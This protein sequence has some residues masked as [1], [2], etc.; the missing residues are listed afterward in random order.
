MSRDVSHMSNSFGRWYLPRR[1][2]E[3]CLVL[4]LA[5]NLGDS[6][7]SVGSSWPRA[8]SQRPLSALR[9]AEPP[10]SAGSSQWLAGRGGALVPF[11][12]LAYPTPFACT[13]VARQTRP[14][15]RLQQLFAPASCLHAILD[16]RRHYQGWSRHPYRPTCWE[17][18]TVIQIESSLFLDSNDGAFSSLQLP[19]R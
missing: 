13:R 1:R 4:E 7:R 6:A 11:A 18:C 19:R 17:L 9:S 2:T 5:F 10:P 14:S 16:G 8:K 12:L 15:S 3:N